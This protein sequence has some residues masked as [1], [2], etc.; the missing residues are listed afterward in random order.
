MPLI[1]LSEETKQEIIDQTG[2]LRRVDKLEKNHDLADS[3]GIAAFLTLFHVAMDYLVH[4]Q[5]AFT[6]DFDWA[7]IQSTSLP[8]FPALILLIY[9]TMK[10]KIYTM[11]Q[12]V[13]ACAG[14][15]AGV[16]LIHASVF[17]MTFG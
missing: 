17:D 6:A 4:V 9:S 16:Y 1:D 15:V 14:F 5:F 10:L 8:M 12:I 2:I 13:F 7:H 3:V 11:G